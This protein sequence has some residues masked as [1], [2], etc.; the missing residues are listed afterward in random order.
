MP[1]H[2]VGFNRCHSLNYDLV[3]KAF[4]AF[5]EV[6]YHTVTAANFKTPFLETLYNTVLKNDKSSIINSA[7]DRFWYHKECL[8]ASK[9]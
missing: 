9:F 2:C 6:F 1:K 5:L 4:V 7:F 3:T 8:Q